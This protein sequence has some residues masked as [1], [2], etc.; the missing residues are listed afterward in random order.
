MEDAGERSYPHP[1]WDELTATMADP[2]HAMP[3]ER[4][5][6]AF[7][8]A[9][10]REVVAGRPLPAPTPDARTAAPIRL[11]ERESPS[12]IERLLGCP[13]S[14][15]LHYRG[16]LRSGLSA[17]PGAPSPL[18]HG[19]LAHHL[20]A[21][22][23]EGGA[24]SAADAATEAERLVDGELGRLCESLALPR[25]QVELTQL[26]VAV[27]ESARRL[28][29]L[30]TATGASVR[31][32]EMDAER[33]LDGVL[34]GGTADLVL[35]DPDVVL[36]LKWG[37]TRNRACMERG[38]ALQLAAYAELFAKG[39][40]RPTVGYFILRTQELFGEPGST[41]PDVTIPGTASADEIWRGASAALA[42]RIAELERGELAAPGA[43]D[44]AVQSGLVDGQLSLEP[45]CKYCELSALCARDGGPR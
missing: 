43:A 38:T 35:A 15:A 32:V 3:L 11:R 13:L 28:G 19:S 37:R 25:Y 20:L 1:L 27:V 29:A 23:F 41:L 2:R 39:D 36:D 9:A 4:R 33:I 31:G 14:W 16:S 44:E 42:L 30:L 21:K 12:S 10:R 7:P 8:A 22:V 45:G 24:R 6:I 40:R 34:V 17:G 18:L 5:T 26:K